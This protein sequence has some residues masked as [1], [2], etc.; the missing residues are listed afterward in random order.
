MIKVGCC[1][2]PVAMSK[3][4][5]QFSLVE[6]NRTFY[7]YPREETAA[8][9]RRKASDEFEFTVKA[10]QDIS[11]KAKMRVEEDSLH[12]FDQMK[13]ICKLLDSRVL[14]FQTPASFRPDRLSYAERYLTEINRDSL[15]LVWETRGPA[16]MTEETREKM[17]RVLKNLNVAHVTDPLRMLPAYAGEVAYFRLHGL[18]KSMYCYQYRNADLSK[19]AEI[20]HSFE[21]RAREVYV[22]F[23]NLAMFDDAS[24]LKYYLASGVFRWLTE[25]TGLESIRSVV[26]KIH[27]PASKAT[28]IRKIGWRLVELSRQKQVSLETILAD[29][30]HSVYKNAEELVRKTKLLGKLT[31]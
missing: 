29:L 15:I 11:H 12:A 13:R 3:Y 17:S 28:L 31:D 2:F 5:E 16:W 27:Y 6:L 9:W 22:L 4:F 8:D 30:P 7:H 19:L 21:R 1:G 25:S 24:R 14:L 23:N 20:L 10:H 18:G 26:E